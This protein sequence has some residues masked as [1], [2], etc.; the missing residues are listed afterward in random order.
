MLNS[1][2]VKNTGGVLYFLFTEIWCWQN[3][4]TKTPVPTGTKIYLNLTILKVQITMHKMGK[5]YSMYVGDA[6][7]V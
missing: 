4:G 1:L 6:K 5:A 3:L 2:Y 7:Y